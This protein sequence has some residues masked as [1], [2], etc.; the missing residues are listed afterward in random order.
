LI[1]ILNLNEK[2][3]IILAEEVHIVGTIGQRDIFKITKPIYL[4]FDSE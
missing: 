2:K 1:G 4:F 3:I